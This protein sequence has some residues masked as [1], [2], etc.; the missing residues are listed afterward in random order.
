MISWRTVGTEVSA[1]GALALSLPLRLF[2]RHERVEA[3]GA[4]P[5]PVV[6]VHGFLGDPTNFLVL[7]TYLGACGVWRFASFA[8]RPRLDYPRLARRLGESIAALCTATGATRV[9]VVG[10]SLGGLVARY[11]LEIDDGHRIRRLVTLGAPYFASPL[12]REEYAIF[13]AEDPFVPV[14]HEGDGPHTTA[15]YGLGRVVVIPHCGHWGLLYHPTVL[16][17]VARALRAPTDELHPA[18]APR[19]ADPTAA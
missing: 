3:A 11:L 10:H 6:F 13:G 2:V 12:P 18:P 16:R 8:Y 17:E 7:R 1:L 19:A 14:P 5:T 4:D 9:G 15:R